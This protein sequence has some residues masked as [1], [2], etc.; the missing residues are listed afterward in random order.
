M[1]S[2]EAAYVQYR[3]K[4]H[5]QGLIRR[6]K[7]RNS[8][9]FGFG[10]YTLIIFVLIQLYQVICATQIISIES[11]VLRILDLQWINRCMAAAIV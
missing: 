5:K 10:T 11:R 2:Q 9:W 6:V 3:Q 1:K 7:V 4:V 8:F